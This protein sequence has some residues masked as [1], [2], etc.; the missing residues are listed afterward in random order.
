M[1]SSVWTMSQD[2][3]PPATLSKLMGHKEQERDVGTE[4]LI[5]SVDVRGC[6]EAQRT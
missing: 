5:S 1:K 4:S 3:D 6:S 2:L